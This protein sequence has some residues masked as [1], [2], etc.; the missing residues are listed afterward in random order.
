MGTS[1]PTRTNVSGIWKLKDITRNI[2]Q[3]GTYPQHSSEQT[4]IYSGGSTPSSQN[5]IET[6]QINTTGNGVD[7]GDLDA[8]IRPTANAGGFT[9]LVDNGLY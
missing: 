4:G 1:Y 7:F 8:A 9:R 6:F 3:E 2:N 5:T